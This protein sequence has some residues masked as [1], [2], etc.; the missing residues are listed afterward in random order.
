MADVR[1]D[2]TDQL[3]LVLHRRINDE[4]I[5]RLAPLADITAFRF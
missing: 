4:D 5:V 1:D 3:T 2:I